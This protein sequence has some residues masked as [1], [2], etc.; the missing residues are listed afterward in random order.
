[1]ITSSIYKDYTDTLSYA[2]DRYDSML[3]SID[4]VYETF[5]DIN[6]DIDESKNLSS[7]IG[8]EGN[9]NKCTIAVQTHIIKNSGRTV[10]SWLTYEGIKVKQRFATASK[11]LGFWISNGNIE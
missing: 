5:L 9:I 10:D 1:M 3:L 7:F 2:Y 8:I 6:P 4:D 11:A